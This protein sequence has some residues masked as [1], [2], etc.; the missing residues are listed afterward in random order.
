[1][2]PAGTIVLERRILGEFFG[3]TQDVGRAELLETLGQRLGDL[4]RELF[5][6]V[7]EYALHPLRDQVP[8]RGRCFRTEFHVASNDGSLLQCF[9]RHGVRIAPAYG[10][11]L[12]VRR[13]YA[14][15]IALA[16]FRPSEESLF[17]APV[18]GAMDHRILLFR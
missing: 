10:D 13:R 11:P 15:Q 8:A 14:V 16:T 1:M 7:A 9:R 18:R 12:D 2:R 17:M 5:G 3:D 4:G 6:S